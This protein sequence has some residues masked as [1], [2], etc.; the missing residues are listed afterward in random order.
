MRPARSRRASYVDK[1]GR[2]I[3]GKDGKPIPWKKAPTYRWLLCWSAWTA[4]GSTRAE[5]GC[6]GEGHRA[7]WLGTRTTSKRSTHPHQAAGQSIHAGPV[8]GT[9]HKVIRQFVNASWPDKVTSGTQQGGGGGGL[10]TRP[11]G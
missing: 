11:G 5:A 8:P 10:G 9:P 6:D 4:V 1:M 3:N 2:P 7:Y